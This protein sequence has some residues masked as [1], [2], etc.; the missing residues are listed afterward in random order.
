MKPLPEPGPQLPVFARTSFR[1]F[2]A[3]PRSISQR[4]PQIPR[5]SNPGPRLCATGEGRG[6]VFFCEGR[7]SRG[8]LPL[9]E[10]APAVVPRPEYA[11]PH[12]FSLKPAGGRKPAGDCF[13]AAAVRGGARELTWGVQV[14]ATSARRGARCSGTSTFHLGFNSSLN[15]A[16]TEG[17]CR[18]S[19]PAPS[20]LRPQDNFHACAAA[21]IGVVLIAGAVPR[22]GPRPA[23][24]LQTAS[25]SCLRSHVFF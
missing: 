20:D 6:C 9:F 3:E 8:R 10:Q 11:F 22:V 18:R 2:T 1:G 19:L 23:R 14:E 12:R 15:P 21:T 13:A 5:P 4:P 25:P 7:P 17:G 16:V 24:K